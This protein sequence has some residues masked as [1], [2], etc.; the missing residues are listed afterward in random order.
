MRD[1]DCVAFLQ[2]ALPQLRM[3]WP[4]FRK[5]RRQVCRRL[6][7]R[8]KQLDL[9]DLDAYRRV[10]ESDPAEWVVVDAACVITVSRFYR[11]RQIWDALQAVVLP[12]LATQALAAGERE[13]RCL[14]IGCASGEE[15]YTLSILWRLE[16]ASRFP[17]LRLRIDA[18]DIDA[19]ML[20]RARCANYS[21]GSLKDLPARW[22]ETAF[23]KSGANFVLKDT[24][25]E[26]VRLER[27]D[28]REGLPAQR[29]DLVLCRN[30]VFTY[31]EP[32]LQETMLARLEEHIAPCGVLVIGAHESLPEGCVK[33]LSCFGSKAIY[34]FAPKNETQR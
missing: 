20:E 10:L 9:P 28:V 18:L 8:L 33:F 32:A 30:L 6:D 15:P 34:R 5:V 31:Y 4:G 16:L 21:H 14:S 27:R 11:D 22:R 2:W 29:Y 13:L 25:R 23:E 17:S 12:Q 3:C 24:F 1:S 7:R 26:G 19:H